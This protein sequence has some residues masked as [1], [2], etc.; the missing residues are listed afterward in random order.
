MIFFLSDV[1][2][3]VTIFRGY[4]FWKYL[5]LQ[6]TIFLGYF[7]REFLFFERNYS[8]M[9]LFLY[10][11][12]SF[13]LFHYNRQIYDNFCSQS[14]QY[15]CKNIGLDI[16]I[17]APHSMLNNLID[18]IFINF[19]LNMYRIKTFFYYIYLVQYST[20]SNRAWEPI[21]YIHIM[22]MILNC[23]DD[24]N[25]IKIVLFTNLHI[26]LCFLKSILLSDCTYVRT[27]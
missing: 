19:D 7:L 10:F 4:F 12:M 27:L 17:Q 15:K 23:D 26:V 9:L 18:W 22:Q 25:E 24:D 21:H 1:L 3:D 14:N 20:V 11:F 6:V 13:T 8:Y 5:F 2:V 16:W